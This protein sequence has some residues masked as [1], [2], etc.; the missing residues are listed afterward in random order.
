M[1]VHP[2]AE[3]SSCSDP[4]AA[5]PNESK[6]LLLTIEP[7]TG[8]S[9]A[10]FREL[11]AHRELLYLL[12]LRDIRVRYKQTVLGIAWAILQPFLTMVVFS[13]FFGKLARVPSDGVP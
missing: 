8:W 6:R 3:Y 2:L 11:W 4:A 7:G 10:D 12:T 9:L 5:H 1:E 13:V